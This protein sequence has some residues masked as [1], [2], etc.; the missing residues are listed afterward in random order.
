LHRGRVEPP[1][2][3]RAPAT[4]AATPGRPHPGP[5]TLARDR[6][7]GLRLRP[8]CPGPLALVRLRQWAGPGHERGGEREGEQT[9]T[10]A[11]LSWI[12]REKPR[13]TR[14]QTTLHIGRYRAGP[15]LLF[16]IWDQDNSVLCAL[17]CLVCS[18]LPAALKSGA[19]RG[20]GTWPVGL[21]NR[22]STTKSEAQSLTTTR[23]SKDATHV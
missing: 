6:G 17:C 18:N 21:A 22:I 9:R 13:R 14:R 4:G 19:A 15:M 1:V 10:S 20:R 23:P 7:R 3:A 16:Q 12:A 5:P 8:P 2:H 11:R